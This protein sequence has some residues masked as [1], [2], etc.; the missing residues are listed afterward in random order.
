MY[1]REEAVFALPAFLIWT[2]AERSKQGVRNSPATGGVFPF[3]ESFKA[4]D[5]AVEF[6]VEA[7]AHQKELLVLVA[8]AQ[9]CRE[10][11]HQASQSSTPGL[12]LLH[13]GQPQT[14][15]TTPQRGAG[16]CSCPAGSVSAIGKS[17]GWKTS[18]AEGVHPLGVG[19]LAPRQVARSIPCQKVQ[20]QST[21]ML[22]LS[23]PSQSALR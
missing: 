17:W 12:H 5:K 20:V 21:A 10:E 4:E 8:T 23:Q 7:T 19:L 11:A 9:V 16:H 14:A 18:P 15:A 6:L 13:R 3:S 1:L 2:Q 22:G